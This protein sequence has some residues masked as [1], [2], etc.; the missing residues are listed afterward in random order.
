M[1]ASFPPMMFSMEELVGVVKLIIQM[2]SAVAQD[3]DDQKNQN[4]D[5]EQR[6]NRRNNRNNR[7]NN[8]H[9][10]K[11]REPP[12]IQ[13]WISKRSKR[14]ILFLLASIS[15]VKMKIYSLPSSTKLN[16][17]VL[18]TKPNKFNVCKERVCRVSMDG[19]YL[20][21][22]EDCINLDKR[23]EI[24]LGIDM[25]Y[26]NVRVILKQLGLYNY[27]TNSTFSSPS[28]SGSSSSFNHYNNN[29]SSS[30]SSIPTD[31]Y[32]K[33][34][35]FNHRLN[36]NNIKL[37]PKHCITIHDPATARTLILQLSNCSDRTM[38]AKGL[39]HLKHLNQKSRNFRWTVVAYL[40]S[41]YANTLNAHS[42][43]NLN[44]NNKGLKGVQKGLNALKMGLTGGGSSKYKSST[45]YN[46]HNNNR[47][48]SNPMN[49][50]CYFEPFV[51]LIKVIGSQSN[52]I[53]HK[54]PPRYKEMYKR[55]QNRL[56]N[57]QSNYEKFGEN[58][59][60]Y[61]PNKVMPKPEDND[62]FYE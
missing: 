2:E 58:E 27:Y 29:H 24:A 18:T 49:T 13:R 44:H 41:K 62:I 31:E 3:D 4:F 15:G 6:Q 54:Y 16:G 14:D 40:I 38:W 42:Q 32:I 5:N 59:L 12:N 22:G 8:K 17:R 61:D 48:S 60:M 35:R 47:S 9:H 10:R 26:N 57:N 7:N 1:A 19:K 55:R 33:N 25:C 37:K 46:N 51:Q 11:E 43:N 53:Q 21:M 20:S 36:G 45:N 52:G 50:P 30:A 34:A 56:K 39:C 23:L 28:D